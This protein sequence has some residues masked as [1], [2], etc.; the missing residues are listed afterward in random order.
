MFE[1]KGFVQVSLDKNLANFDKAVEELIEA[2]LGADA[3]DFDQQPDEE[4]PENVSLR[5]CSPT[6]SLVSE[7]F[8]LFSSSR[9]H[10]K[11]CP[12][13]ARLS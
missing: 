4:N 6:T 8:K 7:S 10:L 13:S 12:R 1:R 11:H 9:L 3:E 5:V 2:A